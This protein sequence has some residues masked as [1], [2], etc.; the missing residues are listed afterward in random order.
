MKKL[1][2]IVVLTVGAVC[3]G[4]SVLEDFEGS[5]TISDFEGLGGAV[6]EADPQTGGT[7][8]STFKLVT[9]PGGNLWQ[10]AQVDLASGNYANLTSD[11]TMQVDVYSTTAFSLMAKVE[12]HVSTAPS[13]A[14]TQAHSGTGWE[15]LTF[16]FT[17]GSDGTTTANGVYTRVAFFPNRN[18][19]DSGWNS[20]VQPITMYADNIKAVKH[21]PSGPTCS[22]GIMNGDETFI[23]CGGTSCSPCSAAPTTA[24]PTP[25]ARNAT[26]VISL[27]SDA[28]TD[29]AS[30]FDAGWC[31]SNSIAEV[32]IAGNA[33]QAFRS[34]PCQGIV[35]NDGIDASTFTN[36]HVDVYIEA[37]TDVTSSVFN[38]KFVQQPGA[39]A[40]EVNFNAA[41]SP[42]LVAGSW[43]S[44]DVPVNL[45]A[46]TGFKE[47]G[48]TSNLHNKVW[49]DNLYAY[50][51]TAL[52]IGDLSNAGIVAYPNPV[53][54][55]LKINA[56][57]TIDTVT[58]YDL[59]GREVLRATPNVE[60]TSL[61]VSSL[62]KGFY[63]LTIKSGDQELSTKLVK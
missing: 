40:L 31:G 51:G 47:F 17:T 36:L 49:Y 43:V 12:D 52:S 46:F 28:Y 8:G 35:L 38:V 23:D 32:D 37:G 24:A 4:Q 44:I 62:N 55:T 39:A 14:N 1:F 58:I 48:I 9:D 15:T 26:D 45:S 13:A 7:H 54:N 21:V 59:T 56:A 60:K 34:N 41:S 53:K 16:T 19:A 10:G 11:K 57:T 27:Y 3:F 42:A 30:N 18:A 63:L 25:P 33:T 50:K 61:D 29:V 5:P 22:D 20:P 6:I 2:T